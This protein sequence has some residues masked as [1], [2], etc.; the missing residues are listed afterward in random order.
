MLDTKNKIIIVLVIATIIEIALI[1][2]GVSIINDLKTTTNIY[3]S[4]AFICNG[5]LD[6]I[7]QDY[8][9]LEK[10]LLKNSVN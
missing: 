1:C 8:E 10:E 6:S 5:K 7:T 3:K 4:N 2:L 9:I